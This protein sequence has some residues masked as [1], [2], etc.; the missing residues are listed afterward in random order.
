MQFY[1]GRM[2]NFFRFR[3]SEN[4]IVLDLLLA[5]KERINKGEAT[6]DGIYDEIMADPK[7]Y[8]DA[9]KKNGITNLMRKSVV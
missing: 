4:S 6:L 8:I 3:E 1:C 9:V 7:P 5:Q 2:F